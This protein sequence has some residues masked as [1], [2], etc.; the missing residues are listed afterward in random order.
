M[1]DVTVRQQEEITGSAPGVSFHGWCSEVADMVKE[2]LHK[3]LGLEREGNG[4]VISSTLGPTK[5]KTWSSDAP[6]LPSSTFEES[7]PADEA[8]TGA[9]VGKRNPMAEVC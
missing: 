2:K 4:E 3:S 8:T 5:L 7:P 6:P 1:D 9:T